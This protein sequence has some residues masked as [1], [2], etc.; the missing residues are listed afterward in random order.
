MK[1]LALDSS[2]KAC[3]VAITEDNQLLAQI[4]LNNGLTHSKTLLPAVSHL[5]EQCDRTLSDIDVLAVSVGPG[6]FTG[7]RIG[8]STVKGLSYGL[9]KP[10]ASCSTL[11]SMAWQMQHLEG[12]TVV[13]TM[14]ARKN[15]VYHS[16]F[17]IKEGMPQRLS[18][19]TALSISDL[20]MELEEITG[21]KIL[22]GDG[23]TLCHQTLEN[24]ELAPDTLR[25][26]TAFSVAL[27]GYQLAQKNQLVTSEE[28]V[29]VYHRLSQAERERLEKEA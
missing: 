19:D 15:Q 27:E 24:I 10:C 4:F 7:L 13:C 20:A 14:D 5:L 3:S 26:Q 28:L 21:P 2:A 12:Y 17:F 23:A 16:R 9:N 25:L 18:Q 8:V 11:A 6:S 29:P 1:I 22:V